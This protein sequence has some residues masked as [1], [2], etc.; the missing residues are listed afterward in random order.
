MTTAM[1]IFSV[2]LMMKKKNVAVLSSKSAMCADEAGV[3][4]WR[5]SQISRNPSW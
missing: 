5:L 2:N 1:L 4:M 3:L